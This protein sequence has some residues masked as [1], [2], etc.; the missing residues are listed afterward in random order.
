MVTSPVVV[1]GCVARRFTKISG[2]VAGDGPG[3]WAE[4]FRYLTK[5]N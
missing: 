4:D 2:T 1:S 3:A 5:G